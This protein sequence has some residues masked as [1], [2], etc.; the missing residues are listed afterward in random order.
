M[1]FSII[2][3]CYNREKLISR[4]IR[5]A[6]HQK[7]INRY[8]YEIIV[9]D[10]FS[11]DKSLEKISEFDSLVRVLKNKK[12][13]GL[14][15]SRNAGLKKAKGKYVVMLDSD[16]FLAENFLFISGLFL[17]SNPWDAAATDYFKVNLKG[18]KIKKVSAKKNPIACGILF[19]KKTLESIKFYNQKLR[20]HEEIDLMKR[21]L[22]KYRLG[23]INLPLYRYTKHRKSLTGIKKK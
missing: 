3:T 20:L 18:V 10:D 21:F 2:I 15:F 23:Y 9:V 14:A 6:L 13:Y 5:S 16:D 22:K 1:I 17:E 4:C 11:K 12:N 19:K 7:N 8:D